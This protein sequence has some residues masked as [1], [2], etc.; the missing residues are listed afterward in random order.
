MSLFPC[1][2]CLCEI[3]TKANKCPHCGR[4]IYYYSEAHGRELT[5]SE[6]LEFEYQKKGI[7]I[8]KEYDEEK[9]MRKAEKESI[10]AQR[11]R[12]QEYKKNSWYSSRDEKI[13]WG[14]CAG[15]SHKMEKPV[16]EIRKY[17]LIGFCFGS[18]ALYL[19]FALLFKQVNTL[20]DEG[21]IR[22][23]DF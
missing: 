12:V 23:T 4:N 18:P 20:N 3:S 10:E 5:P 15:I 8:D 1:P 2:D 9:E 21:T 17:F 22:D 13:I 6:A 11:E 7:F 19:I 14:V 16:G